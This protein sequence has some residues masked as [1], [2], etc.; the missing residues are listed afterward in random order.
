MQIVGE[1]VGELAEAID[2]A[3]AHQGLA[4]IECAIDRDDCTEEL[5]KWG[6]RVAVANSRPPLTLQWD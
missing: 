1:T 2:Q 5:L 3:Q 4:L 6:S